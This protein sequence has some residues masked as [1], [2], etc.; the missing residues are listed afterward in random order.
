MI[1][2]SL[3]APWRLLHQP[4][5]RMVKC[6]LARPAVLLGP[7]SA[8]HRWYRKGPVCRLKQVKKETQNEM[9]CL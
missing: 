3:V 8:G 1:R 4:R 2:L 6:S 5:L 9:C 7:I